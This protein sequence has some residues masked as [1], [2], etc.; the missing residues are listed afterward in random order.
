MNLFKSSKFWDGRQKLAVE[1]QNF[2]CEGR[3]TDNLI[4]STCF[5][6][7]FIESACFVFEQKN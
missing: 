6:L 7:K 2:L 3:K 1:I 5:Y 4:D